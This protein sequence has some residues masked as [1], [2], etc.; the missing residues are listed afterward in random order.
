MT[1]S[2][3]RPPGRRRLL[4]AASLLIVLVVSCVGGDDAT[5]TTSTTTA[6][7]TS[8]AS[9]SASA[10][11]TAR[12]AEGATSTATAV[13]TTTTVPAAGFA[14][15]FPGLP[16]LDRPLA[17]IEVL[18]RAL[19]LVAE[20]GGLIIAFPKA[21]PYDAPTTVLDWRSRTARGA[22]EE[23]LLSMALDPEFATN[24]FLYLYYSPVNGAR[25]TTLSRLETLGE[26]ATFA[27]DP[28]SELVILEIEQ[29]FSNH[30]G[31]TVLFGPD[32]LLYL[33]L[34]DGG[35]GGDPEGN[36]QDL[37][38]NLLGSIVRIDVVNASASERYTI[39]R[40][41]PFLGELGARPETFAT[42]M[43]N[44]W[45]MSF[46]R[47]TG[48]LWAG[49]VGQER[50]EEIDIIGAGENHG[51][52]VTEGTA[53]F[54]P[55]SGCDAAGLTPPV[56]QYDH[57]QGCSVTGGHVYRGV[58][59]P[60]LVGWYLYGDF[61]SGNVWA[62]EAASAA[63]GSPGEPLSLW[64]Q[65]PPLASFAE[66]LAGELYLVSFDGRIYRVTP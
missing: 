55:P 9:A 38:R 17:M 3:S 40:D 13:A 42:G 43:R 16:D 35:A 33:S 53:C 45:R 28:E 1:G 47:G 31:G 19:F 56:A 34:G 64:R 37:E 54:E 27:A 39:P 23:G 2:P 44:P 66:D 5:P 18:G 24:G 48:L 57:A 29:P 7:S 46:D 51:W 15:A 59:V 50:F 6:P 4:L 26:G 30:N 49:D 25:R 58:A 61:C 62:L 11:A 63:A 36:G 12:P 41:N 20:Q 65:G 8:T 10:S 60:A 21:G 22:N 52:N 32:G 14:E